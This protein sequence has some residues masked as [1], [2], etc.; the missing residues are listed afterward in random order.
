MR[1]TG[2]AAW[3]YRRRPAARVQRVEYINKPSSLVSIHVIFTFTC[4]G[5]DKHVANSG[6][7]SNSQ[8]ARRR[9]RNRTK[10]DSFKRNR[11]SFS[12]QR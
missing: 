10:I 11:L 1:E 3:E 9:R 6:G 8:A 4:I 2:V 5:G 7:G 12:W